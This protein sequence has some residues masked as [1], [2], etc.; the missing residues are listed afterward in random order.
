[1]RILIVNTRHYYGGGDSNYAL[2]LA[3]LLKKRGHEVSFFAMQGERNLPDP[4]EDLFVSH[5]DYRALNQRKNP[6]AALQVL[7]RSIYSAEARKKFSLLLDRVKPDLIHLQNIHAHIT[8]SVILEAEQRKIPMVWTLHD[9]KLVCPNS[10]FL[11]DAS[12]EIC[13]A[14]RGGAFWNAAKKRCKKGSLP[15][16]GMAAL[17]A[18]AHQWMNI[19]S[20]VSAFL[21][22]SAFLRGKLLE[23]G[24]DPHKTLH[25]PLFL[26]DEAFSSQTEDDGYILFLGKL[27][28]LKGI[29][30][31]LEA[32]RCAPQV[33][34]WIAGGA[35]EAM[36]K[37]LPLLLPPNV[38]YLGFQ[39]GQELMRLKRKARALVL[40]SLSYENQPLSILEAFALGKP[41]IASDLGGM[42]ELVGENERGWLIPMGD[43]DALAK[44]LTWTLERP[45]ETKALG[46]AALEYARENHTAESHYRQMMKIYQGALQWT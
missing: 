31:L 43:A 3:D 19:R 41:V 20:K 18:Y 32:A 15:A 27:E 42:R 13:E 17:E 28:A 25:L 11:I 7:T 9:Y 14:C 37:Q 10:H 29:Y 34:V 45:V 4:N 12:G 5:I 39:S 30:V 33:P 23:N 22:P 2:D 38:K 44:A 16:S 24:F 8:P 36:L 6:L 46:K 35:D 40:P 1:M 21:C 26:P